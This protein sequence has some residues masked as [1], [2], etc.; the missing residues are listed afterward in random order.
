MFIK[1]Y[2]FIIQKE[3]VSKAYQRIR[4]VRFFCEFPLLSVKNFLHFSFPGN[5]K[6]FITKRS[7]GFQE[8]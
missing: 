2:F 5:F 8:T 1:I 7:F 6:A 3:E 4:K